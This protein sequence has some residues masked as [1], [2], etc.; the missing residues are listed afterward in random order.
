MQSDFRQSTVARI[1]R[2]YPRLAAPSADASPSARWR[3]RYGITAA[4][5]VALLSALG[6]IGWL[7]GR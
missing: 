7:L 3:R 6:L 5:I 1:G 4:A 2:T